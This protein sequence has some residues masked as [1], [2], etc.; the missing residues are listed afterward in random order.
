MLLCCTPIICSYDMI[1]RCSCTLSAVNSAEGYPTLLHQAFARARSGASG[2]E[3]QGRRG[4]AYALGPYATERMGLGALYAVR[5]FCRVA[6]SAK[7]YALS[8]AELGYAATCSTEFGY[9]PAVLR[10]TECGILLQAEQLG[11][12]VR[13]LETEKQELMEIVDRCRC[14]R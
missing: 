1:L 8:G 5:H 10:G 6:T 3:C 12:Q 11:E 4:I 7:S 13:Q 2:H 9:A 14:R